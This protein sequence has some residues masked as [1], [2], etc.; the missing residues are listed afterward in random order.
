VEHLSPSRRA[1][2]LA[3]LLLRLA[4]G[5]N[6]ADFAARTGGL[7]ARAIWADTIERYSKAGLLAVDQAGFRLTDGGI[8]VADALAAEFLDP[9]L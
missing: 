6:F 2:E 5:L 9:T 8:A 4:R 1:G 3:M 7:D